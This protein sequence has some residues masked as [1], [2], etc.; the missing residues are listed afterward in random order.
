M[1][2]K[3]VI[4]DISTVRESIFINNLHHS[5]VYIAFILC[6]EGERVRIAF[7][8]IWS[9]RIILLLFW[10]ITHCPVP[11]CQNL[12]SQS[13]LWHGLTIGI[14]IAISWSQVCIRIKF[15]IPLNHLGRHRMREY[16]IN[17]LIALLVK[18]NELIALYILFIG[19]RYHYGS[20]IPC[21]LHA[22]CFILKPLLPGL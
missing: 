11:C 4:L 6:V 9:R 10:N 12:S 13:I 16:N 5:L 7:R 20:S 14:I 8:I 1:S 19:R 21:S 15:K 17:F 2:N 22:H 3:S 18:C